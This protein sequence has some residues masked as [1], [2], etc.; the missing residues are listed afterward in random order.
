MELTYLPWDSKFFHKKIGRIV[1]ENANLSSLCTLMKEAQ[2]ENYQLLYLFTPENIFV[3][4]EIIHAFNGKLVDRKIIYRMTWNNINITDTIK[5]VEEYYG[6]ELT[7]ELEHLAYLS[8]LHSRFRIDKHFAADDFNRLYNKW[9]TKSVSRELADN[10]FV[11]R[12]SGQITAMVTLKKEKSKGTI[13]LIAV[14]EEYQQKGYGKLLIKACKKWLAEKKINTLEVT[15][16]LTNA[17]A[18]QFYESCG[19]QKL[20]I[21]NIYH[22]RL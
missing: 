19:F 5:D 1:L 17:Q 7:D 11:I 21:T 12:E 4:E 14:S 20:S 10:V 9:I 8:G 13:G 15:T 22:F 2:V 6:E 3:E 18:C 16:Q